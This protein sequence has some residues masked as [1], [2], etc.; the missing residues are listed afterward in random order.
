M[1][2]IQR[3]KHLHFRSKKGKEKERG[4]EG[5][6]EQEKEKENESKKDKEKEKEHHGGCTSFPVKKEKEKKKAKENQ[7]EAG[8]NRKRKPKVRK[9]PWFSFVSGQKVKTRPTCI[10]RWRWCVKTLTLST[11]NKVAVISC[12]TYSKRHQTGEISLLK[13]KTTKPAFFLRKIHSKAKTPSFP[14]KKRKRKRT[15]KRRSKRTG[16]RKGKGK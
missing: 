4:K 10:S 5:Q 6:K 1:R 7:K 12:G 8:K 13:L 9:L 2:K 3:R 15:R 14:V 11:P 16:K